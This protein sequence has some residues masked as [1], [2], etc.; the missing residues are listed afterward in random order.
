MYT[1]RL[2][3]ITPHMFNALIVGWRAC[4]DCRITTVLLNAI[5]PHF[6]LQGRSKHNLAV[7][8]HIQ[9]L[10]T[11]SIIHTFQIKNYT[12]KIRQFLHELRISTL[13]AHGSI[14]CQCALGPSA[15][16][17]LCRIVTLLALYW[18]DQLCIMLSDRLKDSTWSKM[19]SHK[20]L[21]IIRL[22]YFNGLDS[23]IQI[24]I[25]DGCVPYIMRYS[26]LLQS[27]V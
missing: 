22:V 21:T 15:Q 12:G 10:W 24:S 27:P 6:L 1:N 19:P 17:T 7:H 8:E 13:S 16:Y 23:S 2:K 20:P 26:F 4:D 18:Q 25:W 11:C 3:V 14:T 9:Q 5:P